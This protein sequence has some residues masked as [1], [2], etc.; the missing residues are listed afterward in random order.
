MV[1]SD[2]LINMF[3]IG[4][5]VVLMGIIAVGVWLAIGHQVNTSPKMARKAG[6]PIPVKVAT[7]DHGAV[8]QLIAAEGLIKE[9]S[10]IDIRALSDNEILT[11]NAQ[12]G[13]VVSKGQLLILQDTTLQQSVLDVAQAM[14][15]RTESELSISSEAH[16]QTKKFYKDNLISSKEMDAAKLD[17]MKARYDAVNAK[18]ELVHAE[19]DLKAAKLIAPIDGLITKQIA[20]PGMIPAS[21]TV[22]ATLI[23]LDS[24]LV[25]CDIS[26]VKYRFIHVG[27]RAKISFYAFPGKEVEG[28][29]VRVDPEVEE[30]TGNISVQ[31][32]IIN[33]GLELRPG[34]R[35]IVHLIEE[36]E[37]VRVPLVSL[38]NEQDGQAMVFVNDH[39]QARMRKVELGIQG[40]KY[41]V[42]Q[43]GI[44]QG[45]E[46]IVVGQ[47]A[48]SDGDE[49][50]IGDEYES[51]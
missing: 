16:K 28:S 25:Q 3:K 7:A 11:V 6:A 50:R 18:D 17:W 42:V 24:F 21:N 13:D 33:K 43:R 47:A 36:G 10:E 20:R 44:T 48:L 2:R 12:L 49:L 5:V 38:I 1:L 23:P 31:V 35:G 9:S 51:K 37:G 4:F 22:L 19:Y 45:E 34:M 15:E 46:V 27:Q 14:V 40:N 8:R 39:G 30:K 32:G 41:A 26:E 29:V